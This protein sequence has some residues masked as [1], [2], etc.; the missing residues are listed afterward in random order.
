MKNINNK[1]YFY[2][3]DFSESKIKS[4]FMQTISNHTLVG[5]PFYLSPEL[6]DIYLN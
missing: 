4:E 3:T 2:L 5:T 6:N 1:T